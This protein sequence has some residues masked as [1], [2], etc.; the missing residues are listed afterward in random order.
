MFE[1][2]IWVRA[3]GEGEAK[4]C[5]STWDENGGVVDWS[6]AE[7][8]AT[9]PLSGWQRLPIRLLVPEGIAKIQP[10]LIGDG[11][12]R[13]W[14]DDFT[15]REVTSPGLRPIAG[16][17]P[18]LTIGNG[19]L[20]LTLNTSNAT[21]TVHDRRSGRDWLQKVQGDSVV[22]T[23]ASTRGN[24]IRMRVFH[25]PS[26]L[27]LAGRVQLSPDEP[28]FA[29]ELEATGELNSPIEFP[30][31]FET[32]RGDYLVVPMNE[33]ISYPVEDETVPLQRLVAYGGHGIC[34]AFWG[35]TDGQAGQMAIIETPDDAAI[36]T[37][38]LN[39]RLM[40][41][42]EWDAQKQAFGCAR[43]LRYVFF[44][45]GGHVAMAKRYR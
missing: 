12:L 36:K 45:Q 17:P 25:P 29:V 18:T 20:L 19:Q 8:P 32:K 4:F 16:L 15:I 21:L 30:Y 7:R 38:R 40:V 13:L 24:E 14:V 9:I 37:R 34:M 5:V 28:E 39:Q 26:G 10:R 43:R 41:A 2:E 22:L 31:P 23:E 35:V 3:E 1:T 44:A 6:F 27:D 33:G 11:N 42:P